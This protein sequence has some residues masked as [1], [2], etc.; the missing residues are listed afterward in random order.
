MTPDRNL[1]INHR[2]LFVDLDLEVLH[3][4]TDAIQPTVSRALHSGNPELVEA[5]NTPLLQYYS[6]HNMVDRIDT[7][8][9]TYKNMSREVIREQLE[10]WDNNCGCAMAMGEKRLSTPPK[11]CTWSHT[12][13]NVSSGNYAF[14]KQFRVLI[15]IPRFYGG[16]HR[17]KFTILRLSFPILRYH[18]QWKVY[19]PN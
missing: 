19:I 16:K 13:H 17:S 11:K 6:D 15:I 18:F 3:V 12:L 8:Y 14:M 1:I 10:R 9:D 4:S 7:L 5:Y 2:S